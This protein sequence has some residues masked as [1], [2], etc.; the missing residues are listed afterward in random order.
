MN[1]KTATEQ[2]HKY[3][4]ANNIPFGYRK[5]ERICRAWIKSQPDPTAESLHSFLSYADPTGELAARL[6]DKNPRRKN[7]RTT[8]HR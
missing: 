4:T 6:A 5:A 7:D 2:A 1:L 8:D 3:F